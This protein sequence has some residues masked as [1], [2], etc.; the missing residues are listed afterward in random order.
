MRFNKEKFLLTM[1]ACIFVVE[2]LFIAAAVTKCFSLSKEDYSEMCPELGDR[3][4]KL[5][6]V[7]VATTLSLLGATAMSKNGKDK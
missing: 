5:F 4:E 1:L 6:G 2:G 3:T 7:A